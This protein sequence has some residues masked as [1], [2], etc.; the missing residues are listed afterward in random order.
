MPQPEIAPDDPRRDDVTRLLEV[1]LSFASAAS[2]PEDVHALDTD[3]L[4]ASSITFF[5]ARENGTLLGV[6]ALRELDASHGEIKSMHTTMQARG[7]GVGRNLL[8][9]LLKTA[10]E[11]GYTR[12][13]LETGTMDE[14]A[15][16]RRL[17]QA[18]GFEVCPPFNGYWD[19]PHS[20]CMTLELE[21]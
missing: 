12:V 17:Y 5:S 1:H 3:D 10:R 2:P 14:F 20:V 19:S 6:G 8:D 21:Q 9:H 11:R 18:A 4:A 7:R 13:S 15:P 16:A